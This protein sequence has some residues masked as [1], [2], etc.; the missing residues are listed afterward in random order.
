M[1]IKNQLDKELKN[2][3][4]NAGITFGNE[5]FKAFKDQG[6]ISVG[7]FSIGGTSL[8]KQPV[9]TY[10]NHYVQINDEVGEWNYR[11]G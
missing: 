7:Q 2:H 5:L 9:W 3:S 4:S 11:I 8:G 6:W 1:A 10:G